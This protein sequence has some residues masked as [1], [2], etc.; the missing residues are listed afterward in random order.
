MSCGSLKYPSF[1]AREHRGG[2]LEPAGARGSQLAHSQEN[3][4]KRESM[5]QVREAK[6]LPVLAIIELR[7][8][9]ARSKRWA[10]SALV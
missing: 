5:K 9:A 4:V 8:D 1:S 7:T 3:K 10:L 2:A 6:Q